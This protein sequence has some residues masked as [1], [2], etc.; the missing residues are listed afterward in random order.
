MYRTEVQVDGMMCSM[1]EAHIN[2]AVRKNLAVK[3]VS[4]SRRKKRTEILSESPLD[5]EKVRKAIA[6]TGYIVGE[7]IQKEI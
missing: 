7:I 3:K 1:C 6:D 4:S 5:E 2:D